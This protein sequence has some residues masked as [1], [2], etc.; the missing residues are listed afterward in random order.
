M[1]ATETISRNNRDLNIKI[2]L[3]IIWKRKFI[4]G[5]VTTFI[6]L[7]TVLSIWKQNPVYSGSALIEVGYIIGQQ[8]SNDGTTSHVII[9]LEDSLNDLKE[10][11]MKI[12]GI[13]VTF[14]AGSTNLLLLSTE[15]SNIHI[16]KPKIQSA[17]KFITDRHSKK[18]EL[19]SKG[20]Y[21]MHMTQM[22][23][24]IEVNEQPVNSNK[25]SLIF[26]A[27]TS[28]LLLSIFA[29]F[30]FEFIQRNHNLRE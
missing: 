12:T 7:L 21:P 5:S 26:I 19:Y 2:L 3:Q 23:G 16:I 4:I 30:F 17:V 25:W 14:P 22:I 20:N 9:K 15:S 6:T 27:F 11:T 10:I 28:A 13:N 24:K 29:A 8:K 18:A 1:H